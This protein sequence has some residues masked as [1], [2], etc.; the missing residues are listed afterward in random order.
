MT[1]IF[2]AKT[3]H[4]NTRTP[5]ML[6]LHGTGVDGKKTH[7]ILSGKT[8]REVSC[9]YMIDK[10]GTVTQFLDGTVRAWH[11]GL[12]YWAGFTNINSMSIGIEIECAGDDDSFDWPESGYNDLQLK[13]VAKLA[14]EIT[15]TYK[16]LPHNILGHQDIAPYRKKDPGPKFDW[17]MLADNGVGLW[18]GLE[19]PVQDVVIEDK[20]MIAAFMQMLTLYGYDPRPAPEGHNWK[21]VV[22]AFQT[23]F[24]PWNI[25]GL[26]TQQSIQALDILLD[27]KFK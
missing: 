4:Y 5:V 25:C 21:E 13:T 18:H 14:Y 12:S 27:K 24:L 1:Q 9:Q 11:A 15:E 20:Q 22:T 26:V 3:P 23:H 10:A 8:D 17:K 19:K 7:D 2:K 16:I 6:V